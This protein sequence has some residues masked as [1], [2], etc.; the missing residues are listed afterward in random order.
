MLYGQ[1]VTSLLNLTEALDPSKQEKEEYP[2]DKVEIRARLT[3]AG[4]P[5]SP[6]PRPRPLIDDPPP[7]PPSPPPPLHPSPQQ[8]K[9]HLPAISVP[10]PCHLRTTS[11]PPPASL[12]HPPPLAPASAEAKQIATGE[13]ERR[14]RMLVRP[15]SAGAHLLVGETLL[16]E[17][18]QLKPSKAARELSARARPRSAGWSNIRYR[19][20]AQRL[21][22]GLSMAEKHDAMRC[23]ALLR[24][25]A[26]NGGP[27]QATSSTAHPPPPLPPPIPRLTP[28]PRS[29]MRRPRR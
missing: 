12:A 15:A 11:V 29:R 21:G 25:C 2:E 8:R 16:E 10:P 18:G 3:S 7:S 28:G 4:A 13:A 24:E 5:P 22:R 19:E 27:E 9:A 23:M 1:F 20:Q 6:S 26:T 17:L 14:N